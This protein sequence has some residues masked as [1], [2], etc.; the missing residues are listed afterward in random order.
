MTPAERSRRKAPPPTA[1]PEASGWPFPPDVLNARTCCCLSRVYVVSKTESIL[2][3]RALQDV[4]YEIRGQLARRAVE[5]E[6]QGYE[7]LSLNIGNPGLFGFRTPETMRLAMIENLNSSEAYCHQ[8]G[9]FPAREAVVMQQQDRGVMDV[10]AEE[11]FIGNGVSEL[12]D[13]TLRALLNP[14]DEVLI[15][16]PDYPL[17]TA[18]V[19][20][21]SGSPVHYR[22]DEQAGWFPDL[23][24]I[25]S[26]ITSKT[27]AIV[28]VHY[29]GFGANASL[30]KE[31]CDNNSIERNYPNHDFYF[32]R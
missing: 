9:I 13:L 29:G 16:S 24:D 26:K 2:A 5:L 21:S 10:T 17:W 23:D 4:R 19:S 20:L 12:I 22:C 31:L 32:E 7:I 28:I 8:K 15:P 30:F 18:A 11:I 3:S 1:D 6:R 14:G 25:K 27:T